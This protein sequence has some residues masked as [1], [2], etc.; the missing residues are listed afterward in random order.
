MI[1]VSSHSPESEQRD[2]SRIEAREEPAS[3]TAAAERIQDLT[4]S[5]PQSPHQG[6]ALAPLTLLAYNA[7]TT[8]EQDDY[9][10]TQEFGGGTLWSNEKEQLPYR[11]K[12]AVD[13]LKAVAMFRGEGYNIPTIYPSI[14]DNSQWVHHTETLTLLT[15]FNEALD[16]SMIPATMVYFPKPSALKTIRDAHREAQQTYLIPS[17][18]ALPDKPGSHYWNNMG[19]EDAKLFALLLTIKY[20][21]QVTV[22]ILNK[23]P[24]MD[25]MFLNWVRDPP[26][27]Y[28]SPI[29]KDTPMGFYRG[30]RNE[31]VPR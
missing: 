5:R 9:E 22:A 3:L 2:S 10:F 1:E 13:L 28:A 15:T 20:E 26:I 25:P 24:G 11:Q 18:F 16:I 21:A 19:E 23:K 30:Y 6:S 4:S 27:K 14:H 12:M 29:W 31:L 7:L 17:P 8:E